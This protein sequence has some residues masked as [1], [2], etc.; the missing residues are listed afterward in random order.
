MKK[1]ASLFLGLAAA[2]LAAPVL[3]QDNSVYFV[4]YYSNANTTGAPDGIVRAVNDGSTAANMWADIYLFDDS[5][6]L[7]TCCGCLITPDGLISESVN[8]QLTPYAL[9]GKIN[10]RG[11][12]KIVSSSTPPDQNGFPVSFTP[13]PGIRVWGT[14]IQAAANGTFAVT[15]TRF[16]DADLGAT[17]ASLLTNLC[18]YDELLSGNSCNCTK[19]DHAF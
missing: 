10:K 16:A 7:Q 19:E 3:A 4:S 15:E 13:T 9:T 11:V 2:L 17:E 12:L 8:N 5:Q 1:I 6:E 18:Y 14:H